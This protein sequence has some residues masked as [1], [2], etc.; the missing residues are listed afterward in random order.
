MIS[1]LTQYST[2]LSI[3]HIENAFDRDM[4]HVGRCKSVHI[5]VKHGK[6]C[7]G[8]KPEPK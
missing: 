8:P 3:F 5:T 6:I 7:V 2:F 1:A 4:Q